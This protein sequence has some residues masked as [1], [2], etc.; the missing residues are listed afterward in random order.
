MPCDMGGFE[1]QAKS[2]SLDEIWTTIKK[3][4]YDMEREVEQL[5]KVVQAQRERL[6]AI[7]QTF[8]KMSLPELKLRIP[9]E[10]PE[11]STL[12]YD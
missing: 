9:D 3:H 11:L 4:H 8:P 7:R 2:L 5:R 10:T 1:P 12:K 6:K